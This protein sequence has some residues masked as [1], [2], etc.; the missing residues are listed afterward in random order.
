MEEEEPMEETGRGEVD[1]GI[2][3]LPLEEKPLLLPFSPAMTEMRRLLPLLQHRWPSDDDRAT[4]EE[5][6]GPQ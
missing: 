1:E 5:W 4:P 2:G 6:G 3:T